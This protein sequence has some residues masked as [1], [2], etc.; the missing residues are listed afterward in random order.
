MA[1]PRRATP[2][3]GGPSCR[4]RHRGAPAKTPSVLASSSAGVPY[5]AARPRSMTSTASASMTVCSRCAMLISVQ[6]TNSSRTCATTG[7]PASRPRVAPALGAPRRQTGARPH[8]QIRSERQPTRGCDCRSPAPLSH[9]GPRPLSRSPLASVQERCCDQCTCRLEAANGGTGCAQGRAGARRLLDEGVGLDVHIGRGL[10]QH[11]DL[12]PA[13]KSVSSAAT[14]PRASRPSESAGTGRPR[15]GPAASMC[16][17]TDRAQAGP[18]AWARLLGLA[19]LRD[20]LTLTLPWPCA[21]AR[22]PACT[23][24]PAPRHAGALLNASVSNQPCAQAPARGQ[25]STSTILHPEA[26]ARPAKL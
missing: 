9:N 7:G 22:A 14:R 24:A 15:Q 4:P 12:P 18:T 11:E 8:A 21:A 5:S 20:Q 17:P 2:A 19:G 23:A 13:H 6:F 25:P 1:W 3:T 10:V 16:R 26:G